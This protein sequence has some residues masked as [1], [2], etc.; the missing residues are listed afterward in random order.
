MIAIMQRGKLRLGA[1]SGVS[2][3]DRKDPKIKTAEALLE[4][5]YFGGSDIAVARSDD[6]AIETDR[7]ETEEKFRAYFEETGYRAFYAVILR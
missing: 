7:R 5:V 1:V 6:G 2:Q 3:L 4:W